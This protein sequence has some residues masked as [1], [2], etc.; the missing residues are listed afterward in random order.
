MKECIILLVFL[1]SLLST[2]QEK[3]FAAILP[4]KAINISATYNDEC[5]LTQKSES[6]NQYS[7]DQVLAYDPGIKSQPKKLNRFP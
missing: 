2:S 4:V 7:V 5:A 6:E 3:K 1:L